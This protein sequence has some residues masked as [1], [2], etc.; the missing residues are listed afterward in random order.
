MTFLKS[1]T[2]SKNL[3]ILTFFQ[4]DESTHF[5]PA[6]SKSHSSTLTR[7]I[8]QKL[9]SEKPS[10]I[11]SCKFYFSTFQIKIFSLKSFQTKTN[12][13]FFQK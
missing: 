2:T 7:Y 3:E 9:F 6:T 8:K 4:H 5:R 10:Y 12:L 13:K 11:C 1:S